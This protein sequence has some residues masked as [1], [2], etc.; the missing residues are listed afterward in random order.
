MGAAFLMENVKNRELFEDMPIPKAVG[1]MAVPTIVGQI[2]V[3]VYSMADTFF[4]GRTGDPYMVAGASIILPVF[5]ISLS[6]AGLAGIGGGSAISRFLG[7][8]RTAEVRKVYSFS[9]YL[10]LFL[11]ALFSVLVLF[12]MRPLRGPLNAGSLSVIISLH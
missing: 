2:I 7:Q 5:N 11:S 6:I 12:L 4:I 10:A 8:G 1:T 3:L 9:V